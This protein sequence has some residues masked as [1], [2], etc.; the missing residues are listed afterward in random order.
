MAVPTPR[1]IPE[2]ESVLQ[3]D[4]EAGGKHAPSHVSGPITPCF[5]TIPVYP[6]WSSVVAATVERS[7]ALPRATPVTRPASSRSPI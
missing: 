6:R 1:D 3:H 7:C 4:R 2:T 5:T